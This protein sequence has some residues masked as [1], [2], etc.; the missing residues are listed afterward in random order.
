MWGTFLSEPLSIVGLVGRYPANC[1]MERMPIYQRWIFS[2]YPHAGP[3]LHAVLVRLSPGYPPLIGKL[4]TRYSPVRRSPPGIATCAAPRLACV[5]PVASVHPEPGSNSSLF[6]LFYYPRSGIRYCSPKSYF[7][8]VSIRKI[9]FPILVLL[10]EL[11]KSLKELFC[12]F[13]FANVDAKISVF[14]LNFQIISELFS[15]KICFII[16]I[17]PFSLECGCKSNAIKHNLQTFSALFFKFF[18]MAQQSLLLMYAHDKGTYIYL[19]WC[20]QYLDGHGNRFQ[21]SR[22]H[23]PLFL[24]HA[25]VHII[26]FLMIAPSASGKNI[27]SWLRKFFEAIHPA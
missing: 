12:R 22:F 4:H 7:L 1:L 21:V 17:S 8:T 16:S 25:Q 2:K 24:T 20:W 23:E 10:V 13:R 11:C 6:K 15:R 18:L 14:L 5:K 27:M 19:Y 26:Q 3:L 9:N